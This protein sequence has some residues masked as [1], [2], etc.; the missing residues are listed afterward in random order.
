VTVDAVAAH[1]ADLLAD[2]PHRADCAALADEIA[3]MPDP[4]AV[5]AKLLARIGR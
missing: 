2:G 4:D 5:A 1:T 3:A